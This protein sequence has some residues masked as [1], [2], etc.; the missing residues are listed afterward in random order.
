ML[1]SSDNPN[2]TS[3]GLEAV[4]PDN[5][6]PAALS[7]DS[8]LA[9]CSFE[10]L[11]RSGPGGQ[12]R[13]KVETGVRLCHLPSS[14]KAE[15][16]ERRAQG[17]NRQVA[18]FRL[19]VNLALAVRLAG[20]L[21]GPSPLWRSRCAGGRISVNPSH[22]DFPTMLAEALDAIAAVDHDVKRAAELL[23]STTSQLVKLL[24][25]DSRALALVN[26]HR[27]EAGLGTLS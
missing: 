12:H 23:G 7:D 2:N 14:T 6:H 17:E 22:H 26:R 27:A 8:L 3:T 21:S 4:Q 10:R 11:R 1:T 24:K 25:R 20:A 13:N 15:A 16:T 9:A 19:R 18:L 5:V